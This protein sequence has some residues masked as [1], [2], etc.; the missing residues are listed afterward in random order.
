[1]AHWN[2]ISPDPDIAELSKIAKEARGVE[3]AEK[4]ADALHE[5]AS[6]EDYSFDKLDASDLA[7]DLT[8]SFDGEI[9]LPR[10]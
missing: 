4:P 8:G 2:E 1:M 9:G 5:P 10:A 6:E 3:A 7:D